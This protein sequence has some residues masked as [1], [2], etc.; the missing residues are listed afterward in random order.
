MALVHVLYVSCGEGMNGLVCVQ[1]RWDGLVEL[2][3]QGLNEPD[4]KQLGNAMCKSPT[5]VCEVCHAS[6][7]HACACIEM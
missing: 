3:K 1:E 2:R 4:R 6:R 7:V 5:Q